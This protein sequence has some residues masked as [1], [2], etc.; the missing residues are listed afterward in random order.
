MH[1]LLITYN[2]SPGVV[3]LIEGIPVFAMDPDPN[4][5]IHHVANTTL[6]RLEDP[7]MFDPQEWIEGLA[8]SHWKFEELNGEAW[9]F[10]RNYVRPIIPHYGC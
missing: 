7:K 8:M 1:G 3:S 10:M 9:E 2:S 4:Y 6:K 5:S